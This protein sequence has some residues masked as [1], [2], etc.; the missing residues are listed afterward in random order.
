[1]T[2]N[3][4]HDLYHAWDRPTIH[5]DEAKAVYRKIEAERRYFVQKMSLDDCQRFQ[6]LENLFSESNQFEQVSAFSHGFKLG[7]AI[8]SAVMKD[9]DEAI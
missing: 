9:E 3:I 7:A 1:M 5:T 8:M 2:K 6:A 4:L